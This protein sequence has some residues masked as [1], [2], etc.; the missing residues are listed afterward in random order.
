MPFTL[1]PGL[2]LRGLGFD[3]VALFWILAPMLLWAAIWPAR[4]RDT[5]W[6]GGI[7]LVIFFAFAV[8]FIF[9]ALSEWTFWEEFETRFN[10]IAVDYLVYTHEVIGNILESYSVPALLTAVLALAL[11]L[12]WLFRHPIRRAPAPAPQ[13]GWRVMYAVLALLPLEHPASERHRPDGVF[14][15]CLRQ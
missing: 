12:T 2:F 7:R 8:S 14:A 13:A 1:W 5:R 6:Q 3:F 10:F 11:G 15:K 4:W 9:V